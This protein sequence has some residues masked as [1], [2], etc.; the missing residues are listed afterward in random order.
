MLNSFVNNEYFKYASD[1]R[2]HTGERAVKCLQCSKS[3]SQHASL[4]KHLKTCTKEKPFPCN[5]CLKSF[6]QKKNL[7]VH[8]RVHSGE[9]LYVCCHCHKYFSATEKIECIHE[10]TY[11]SHTLVRNH[12]L[13]VLLIPTW[14][15]FKHRKDHFPVFSAQKVLLNVHI[16]QY[17]WERIQK[18]SLTV[19]IIAPNT[20]S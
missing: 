16:W 12:S 20:F 7:K 11:R 10:S 6:S 1:N 14:E 13:V 3:F 4:Q 5:I 9:K 19:V 2:T 8:I 18:R 17:I 15:I